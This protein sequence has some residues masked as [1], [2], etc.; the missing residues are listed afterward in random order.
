MESSTFPRM[1]WTKAYRL[2]IDQFDSQH[3]LLF[4][5]CNELLE[6]ENPKEEAIEFK[7]LF[8]H[9][10]DYVNT[11]FKEE[12]EFMEKIGFPELDDHCN[13]HL[14]IVGEINHILKT[15]QSLPQLRSE[16][17]RLFEEWIGD[18]IQVQDR[19]YADWYNTKYFPRKDQ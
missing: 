7:Y 1:K 16:L 9:L 19:K 17:F 13:Q 6:I 5:I 8:D 15:S 14:K 18:H 2:G 4:A 3:R 11:H 10:R 12:E